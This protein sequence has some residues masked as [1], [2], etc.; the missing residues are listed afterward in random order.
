MAQ[1]SPNYNLTLPEAT[2]NINPSIFFDNFT[3][4]DDVLGTL[5]K[6]EYVV[7]VGSQDGWYYKRYSSGFIELWR[8][9]D[10]IE[11]DTS[12]K[13]TTVEVNLGNI[14]NFVSDDYVVDVTLSTTTANLGTKNPKYEMLILD[15]TVTGFKLIIMNDGT[16]GKIKHKVHYRILGRWA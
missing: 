7:G 1:L 10:E 6:S 4:I 13:R 2:D 11:I 8:V 14:V 3:I 12:G 16:S 15:Q 5:A 9:S